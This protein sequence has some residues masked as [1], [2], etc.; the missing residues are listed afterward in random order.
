MFQLQELQTS[1]GGLDDY[2]IPPSKVGVEFF[3]KSD[4][5]GDS[6]IFSRTGKCGRLNDPDRPDVSIHRDTLHHW[7]LPIWVTPVACLRPDST[8]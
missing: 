5:I 1:M 2:V 7:Q 4:S 8:V 6:D 3:Q